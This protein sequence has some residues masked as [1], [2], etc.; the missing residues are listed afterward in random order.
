MVTRRELLAGVAAFSGSA[1]ASFAFTSR[2]EAA[3]RE[4]I[5]RPIATGTKSVAFDLAERPTALPC[6]DGKTL[7]LWT[8][9]EFR[10]PR[11]ACPT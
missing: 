4:V 11:T 8:F 7:P 2:Q 1:A 5:A 6:F 9:E 10:T 3:A